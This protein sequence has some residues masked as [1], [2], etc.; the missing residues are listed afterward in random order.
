MPLEGWKMKEAVQRYARVVNVV[1]PGRQEILNIIARLATESAP[2]DAR[3][4]DLGCGMGDVS[5]AILDL[6]PGVS[7]VMMDYSEEMLRLCQER[8]TGCSNIQ[9][10][11]RDLHKGL[12][13][14]LLA[15]RFDI[16]VSCFALHHLEF[17][18]RVPLYHEIYQIL[19]ETGLFINGDM[20]KGN[21]PCLDQW[22]FD[23]LI[24][25]MVERLKESQLDPEATFPEATFN[26]IKQAQMENSQL[27]GDKPLS[28]WDMYQ[29]MKE[30]GFKYVDCLWKV[31][32]LA[33]LA[34]CKS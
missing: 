31:Q 29:D 5:A 33:V 34:A 2:A 10:V 17:S 22:E 6:N 15:S 14:E 1:V 4:L 32:N 11:S 8:F 9:I 12:G 21:S 19:T 13:E 26:K 28:I 25:W 30:A 7:L 18:R 23:N 20:F 3:I 16:V 27:M 24:G